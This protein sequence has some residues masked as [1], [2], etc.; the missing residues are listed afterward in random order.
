MAAF[1]QNH[2]AETFISTKRT[3]NIMEYLKYRHRRINHIFSVPFI[4]MII[5]PLILLDVIVE[6]YHRICFKLYKLPYIKRS[7]YIRIDRQ[8]LYYLSPIQK[9][10]CTYCSY[11]NGMLRY[12][13]AI[14]AATEKYW[15]GIRNQQGG[16]F[17]EAPHHK[18]FTPYGNKKKFLKKYKGKYASSKEK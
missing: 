16:N 2:L 12:C 6:I 1:H 15:C 18:D 7:A 13:S 17:I 4:Y 10:N 9:I 11:A 8:M 5:F 3:A 14:A